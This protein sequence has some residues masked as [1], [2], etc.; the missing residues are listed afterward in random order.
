VA[1]IETGGS[2]VT[3]G[4]ALCAAPHLATVLTDFAEASQAA[5]KRVVLF[6]VERRTIDALAEA[7]A[8]YTWVC[9]GEQ[10]IFELERWS[11]A[12]GLRANV[13]AQ[14]N[15]ARN[16]GV[17]AR[18][19]SPESL[20]PGTSLRESAEQLLGEWKEFR[21][22]SPMGFM[23]DLHPFR[24]PQLR[25]YFVAEHAGH[26]VGLLAAVP[27]P[28]RN[29]WFAEDLIRRPGAPNGTAE[30]LISVAAEALRAEGAGMLTFG[31]APLSG[32]LR[33]STPA[34]NGWIP[35]WLIPLFE[36]CFRH[37]NRLYS[38]RGIRAFRE[39]FRPDAWE[40]LYMAVSPA[41][42]TPFV[43][44]DM[45]SAFVP[46]SRLEFSIDTLL[47]LGRAQA[48]K[49]PVRWLKL[50]AWTL[51]LLLIP[52][53]FMLLAVD[54]TR[55]FGT[56]WLVHAW[57]SFDVGMGLAFAALALSLESHRRLAWSLSRIMLGAVLADVWLTSAQVVLFNLPGARTALD[58]GV[59]LL[60][61]LAP[62][63]AVLFLSLVALSLPP[64]DPWSSGVR[65]EGEQD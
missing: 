63:I 43:L 27:V 8:P 25:R 59:S 60:A 12:G 62:G 17:Q 35:P 38:F 48:R 45:L 13:R 41:R 23:V 56:P 58:V 44:V 33:R 2:R 52:W 4:T 26:L 55:H 47:R 32:Q 36:F 19:V 49:V 14:V 21:T 40:P 3:A 42:V 24:A 20:A 7:H 46:G 65:K 37:A 61:V 39:K 31:I 1:Y 15:R 51:S 28:G 64:R 5:G 57:V 11:L 6:G 53:I 29:G 34:S 22:M 10:A 30:L 16:H 54:A 18:A 9:I 50:G